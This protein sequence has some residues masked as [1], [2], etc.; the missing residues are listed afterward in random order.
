MRALEL[1]NS[2]A[3]V[4][5]DGNVTPLGSMMAEFPVD[6]QVKPH[7]TFCELIILLIFLHFCSSPPA[8]KGV[9]SQS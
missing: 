3:A 9:D 4:D 1:L 7:R 6:P 5:D 2:L 8:R